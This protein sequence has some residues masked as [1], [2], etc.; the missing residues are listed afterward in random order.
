MLSHLI[1]NM[2][3]FFNVNKMFV[4]DTTGHMDTEITF[5]VKKNILNKIYLVTN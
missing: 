4:A 2:C 3:L 1:I 5:D